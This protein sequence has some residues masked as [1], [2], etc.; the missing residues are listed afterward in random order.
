MWS[1]YAGD[2]KGIV[3][4][5][6]ANVAK[7]SK[8]QKFHPITYQAKRPSLYEDAVS[9]LKSSVFADQEALKREMIDKIVCAKTLKWEYEG[10]Y[11]LAIP[12]GQNEEP[13]ET[14]KFHPEEITEL[15][16]GL[17]MDEADRADILAKAKALNFGI[18]V[19]QMKRGADGILA[20]NR[21]G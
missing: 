16:L 6:E 20:A 21:S 3:L 7:D 8:F 19:F 2:H 14:L 13:W 18:A 10:E 4:R 15:Y 17:A 12:L 11:R 5:I 9:F 1:G